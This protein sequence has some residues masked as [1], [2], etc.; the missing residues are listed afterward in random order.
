MPELYEILHATANKIEPFI[1]K[2]SQIRLVQVELLDKKFHLIRIEDGLVALGDS[3][4]AHFG[5][6][7]EL[8]LRV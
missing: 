5:E 6:N 7:F 1:S 8:V 2:I 3:M 4:I